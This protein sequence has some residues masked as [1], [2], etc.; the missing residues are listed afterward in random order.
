[1]GLTGALFSE[2]SVRNFSW[3]T[4]RSQIAKMENQRNLTKPNLKIHD[5]CSV[6][7]Q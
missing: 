4:P 1:M 2:F 5:S 7:Q 3:K 6:D